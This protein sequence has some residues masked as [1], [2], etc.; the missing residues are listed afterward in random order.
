MFSP[1][2]TKQRTVIQVIPHV[3][4]ED[5]GVEDGE[6]EHTVWLCIGCYRYGVQ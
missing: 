2:I 5:G 1:Q 3:E 6:G 4:E